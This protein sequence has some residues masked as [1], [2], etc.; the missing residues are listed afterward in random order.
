MNADTSSEAIDA[1]N[2]PL[3][4]S[5]SN[6]TVFQ[7]PLSENLTFMFHNVKS[8]EKREHEIIALVDKFDIDTL[9]LLECMNK[10]LTDI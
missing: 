9:V 1:D 3:N 5:H 6:A 4:S 8:F 7:N 10:P 2:S